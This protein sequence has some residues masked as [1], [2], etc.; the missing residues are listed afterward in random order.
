MVS[1]EEMS[2][3]MLRIFYGLGEIKYGSTGVDVSHFF[4][5]FF[6]NF[7]QKTTVKHLNPHRANTLDFERV[8][9]DMFSVI[10]TQS[11]YSVT[12]KDK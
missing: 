4:Y 8:A 12:I 6:F 3:E 10:Y 1:S 7:L 2:S 9:C 11:L 5:Y